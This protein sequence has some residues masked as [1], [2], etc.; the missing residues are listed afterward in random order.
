MEPLNRNGFLEKVCDYVNNP[1]WK[2][3]GDKPCIIDF[4]DD[5]CMPCKAIEPVMLSVS[6][7]YKDQITFYKVDIKAEEQLAKELGVIYMPTLVLCA[8]D[9]K[10][11]VLQ[12][13]ATEKDLVLKI[14]KELLGN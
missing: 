6:E 3:L 13:A 4:Y 5:T 10:P 1:D 11:I 8:V 2:Y 12:G 14:E 7:K 9:D